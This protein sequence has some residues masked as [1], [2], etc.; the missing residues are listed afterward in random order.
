MSV[1]THTFTLTFPRGTR[2]RFQ[3]IGSDL[4]TVIS[5][6]DS[7]LKTLRRAPNG[8]SIASMEHDPHCTCYPCMVQFDQQQVAATN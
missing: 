4:P 5:Q 3:I 8:L 2:R 7:Q 1:Y 6:L